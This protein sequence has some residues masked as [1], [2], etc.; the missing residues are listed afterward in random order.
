MPAE[1]S[2]RNG[3]SAVAF[4]VGMALGASANAGVTGRPA[5]SL[6]GY[7]T[8]GMVHASDRTADYSSSSM[9]ASGAGYTRRWSPDVDSRLGAQ[10]DVAQGHWSGVLQVVSE[11]NLGG[12]WRPHVEWA[13]IKYQLTPDLA[14]RVG[15][16][17]LPLFLMADY[18][19][20]GYAYQWVR[21]PVELYGALPITSSNGVDVTWRFGTGAVRHTSQAFFGRDSRGLTPSVHLDAQRLAGLSH[22]VETGALTARLSVLTTELTLDIGKE[23]FSGL[24]MAGSQGAMLAQRYAVDHKRA[25]LA[26]FGLSYDPGSWFVTAEAGHSHTSSFLGKNTAVYM[27]GGVRVGQFTPYAGYA[28]VRSGIPTWDAGLPVVPGRATIL[29]SL[30]SG[31]NSLLQTIPVQSTVSA[32][33]RWDVHPNFAL[34]AQV[35]RVTPQD[36]SRGT[37]IN[38]QPDFVSGRPL[39]VASLALDFVF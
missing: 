27:G 28:R 37:L 14:L 18:R 9:K 4:A 15:R 10:L 25:S 16:I 33:V 21:P 12:D 34:K 22:T 2:F 17:A 29:N 3:R 32:G 23:L 35:E 39:Q 11:Q 19:K 20:V 26:S 38:T 5:L 8:L 24:E 31:L 30:N 6:S 1:L 7:G 36:G 13:N